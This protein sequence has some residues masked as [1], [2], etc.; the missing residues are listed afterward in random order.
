MPRNTSYFM[1]GIIWISLVISLA[2]TVAWIYDEVTRRG[3]SFS[4]TSLLAVT[5]FGA[6]A[7]FSLASLILYRTRRRPA[8]VRIWLVALS[9]SLTYTALDV[10]TGLALIRP[11][12]PP[13]IPDEVVHHKLAPN[14]RSH[15]R[16]R[17]FRYE[18]R[19][20]DL[21][22][23]GSDIEPMKREDTYR[24]LMLGDSFTMG[25]GVGDNETFSVL[26][27]ELL[28]ARRP[29]AD[30]TAFQ[31]LNAG[32]DSYA[33]I[34]SALQLSEMAPLLDPD[35][36]ALNFDMSD[37]VQE[38]TYRAQATRRPDDGIMGVSGLREHEKRHRAVAVRNW[39]DRHL[40]VTRLVIYYIHKVVG[41][42]ADL[43]I[44][45][46]VTR[47]GREL[48]EHTLADD[49]TDRGQQWRDVFESILDARR[50][51]ADRGIEFLLTIYPWG[52][53]VSAS[54]WVPGRRAFVPDGAVVSD[55]SVARLEAFAAANDIDLLN[56]FPAFRAYDGRSLLYFSYD[57]HWTP[58]GHAL[59]AREYDRFLRNTIFTVAD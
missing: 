3:A 34:L 24:I 32:V 10:V 31:V 54:E 49:E 41:R 50:Y 59:A 43:T 40:Y 30:A 25:K 36:V 38:A 56:M 13:T 5:G 12:S 46:S 20:N 17:S 19:V 15:Y 29:A 28:N 57:M 55:R 47:A 35:F 8:V 16:S 51:C 11:L 18:Q 39:I 9:L 44:A 52:H 42:E 53:Q 7:L 33:P 2:L 21:G 48:L 26:L 1:R 27:E 22:L 6:W 14:S 23:R 58:A 37:L 4:A 45:N